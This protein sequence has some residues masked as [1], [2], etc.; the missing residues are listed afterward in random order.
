[1][2]LLEVTVSLNDDAGVIVIYRDVY[3]CEKEVIGNLTHPNSM[4]SCPGGCSSASPCSS[5]PMGGGGGNAS[6]QVRDGVFTA[7][8]IAFCLGLPLSQTERNIIIH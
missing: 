2:C 6:I 1:M 3:V 4:S 5:S 8:P 7:F